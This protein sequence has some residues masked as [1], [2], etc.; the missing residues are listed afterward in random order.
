M[1]TDKYGS[2]VY[3]HLGN[4]Y[5]AKISDWSFLGLSASD[6]QTLAILNPGQY[7]GEMSE[8]DDAGTYF[9][10]GLRQCTQQ[11]IYNYLCTRNNNF[12]N[13]S[14]QGI[15]SVDASSKGKAQ[16]DGSASTYSVGGL[17]VSTLAS[18]NTGVQIV[19]VQSTP[20][21]STP[22]FENSGI[23]SASDVACLANFNTNGG[24]VV[25]LS[26]KYEE[27]SLKS[28]DFVRADTPSGPWDSVDGATIEDGV[29]T[30]PITRGGCYTV[31]SYPNAGIITA[32]V[33]ACLVGVGAIGGGL[34]WKFGR[35]RGTKGNKI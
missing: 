34:Y 7:G 25:N 26:L 8:L 2:P 5:P 32:I 18:G 22:G 13:R 30:A 33:L 9:D 14:Q 21:A 4:S 10:L 17:T 31:Q 20:A 35:N 6:M 23:S 1:L 19:D 16:L 15:I 27:D 3:G 28:F 24:M 11:G 29:A 12:S